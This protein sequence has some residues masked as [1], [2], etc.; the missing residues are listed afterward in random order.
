MGFETPPMSKN[1]PGG[2]LPEWQLFEEKVHMIDG[3]Q[4]TVGFNDPEGKYYRLEDD[5]QLV[6]IKSEDGAGRETF[7][8]KNGQDIPFETWKQGK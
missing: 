5:E 4:K 3:K 7:I 1:R 8:R 6:H 2:A